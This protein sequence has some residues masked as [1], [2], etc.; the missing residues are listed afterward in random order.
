MTQQEVLGNLIF[1]LNP[2]TKRPDPVSGT[3]TGDMD[4]YVD[5]P[6]GTMPTGDISQIELEVDTNYPADWTFKGQPQH[7]NTAIR[8]R[9]RYPVLDSSSNPIYYIDDYILVGFEGS[10]GP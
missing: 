9:Y 4:L 10:G 2:Y 3:A 8:I 7:V 5:S 6:T 1:A